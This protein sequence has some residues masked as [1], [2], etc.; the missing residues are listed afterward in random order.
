LKGG[1]NLDIEAVNVTR[2]EIEKELS[3]LELALEK[4]Y[5]KKNNRLVKELLAVYGHLKLGGKVIDV[6][7]AFKKA[8]KI[9]EQDVPRLAIVRADASFCH[10]YK[11]NNGGAL[12][13]ARELK[14]WHE[15]NNENKGARDVKLPIGTYQWEELKGT[16]RHKRTLVPAIPPRVHLA[17]STRLLREHYHII[18]E[19]E[20]WTSY[21]A[22]P[23]V[24]RDPILVRRLTSNL[25]GVLATWELTELET[26][27]IEG[28]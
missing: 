8:G 28:L 9:E 13:S 27:I 6:A 25:F 22:Q 10:L 7:D 5:I 2:E 21:T 19:V 18:F 23:R 16:D 20:K 14:S 1:E 11:F 4:G 15:S 12:F 17:V 26:K 3:E 24:P